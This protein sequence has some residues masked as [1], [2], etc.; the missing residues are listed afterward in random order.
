MHWTIGSF[1]LGAVAGMLLGQHSVWRYLRKKRKVK[2][3]DWEYSA[4]KVNK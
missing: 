2:I 4:T 1:L 3:V